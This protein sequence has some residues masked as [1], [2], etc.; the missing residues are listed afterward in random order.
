[1]QLLISFS[2]TWNPIQQMSD[3]G[4]CMRRSLLLGFHLSIFLVISGAIFRPAQAQTGDASALTVAVNARQASHG[5]PPCRIAAALLMS[6]TPRHSNYQV[7]I[8][9]RTRTNA[10]GSRPPI[11]AVAAGYGNG[12]QVF[13]FENVAV[14]VALN[15]PQLVNVSQGGITT[16]QIDKRT[17][18]RPAPFATHPGHAWIPADDESPA[19]ARLGEPAQNFQEQTQNNPNADSPKRHPDYL[20]IAVIGLAISGFSLV[21][22][23]SAL[24]R[25]GM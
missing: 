24:K 14:G 5:L 18:V 16:P 20:L 7:Q 22:L 4:R 1:M 8:G 12:A 13:E 23:G 9:T 11:R 19:P 17:V 21:L 25:S 3:L 10:G 6:T 2:G 15:P